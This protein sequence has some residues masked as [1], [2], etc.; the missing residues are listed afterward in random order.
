MNI[1]FDVRFSSHGEF[2]MTKKTHFLIAIGL[3][4]LNAAYDELVRF[5]IKLIL[6][7]FN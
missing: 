3:I 1:N 6:N 2:N 4:T 5:V 7:S